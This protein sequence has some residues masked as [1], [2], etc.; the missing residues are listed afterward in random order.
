MS[1]NEILFIMWI[2]TVPV[3]IIGI[4]CSLLYLV[5]IY[6]NNKLNKKLATKAKKMEE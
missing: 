2:N 1:L 5:V 6:Q 4:G 3:G